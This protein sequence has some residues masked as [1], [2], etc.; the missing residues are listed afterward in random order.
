VDTN[1]GTDPGL[2]E[3]KKRRT[4]QALTEAAL[5]LFAERGFDATTVADIA[6]AA[7]V[8]PRT[9]FSYF[10][11]KEDAVLGDSAEEFELAQQQLTA[12]PP[13]EP[14][15]HAMRRLT[16]AVVDRMRQQWDQ[17]LVRTQVITNTPAILARIRERWDAWEAILAAELA[18]ELG[19]EP[20]DVEPYVAAAAVIGAFRA[21]VQVSI[22]TQMRLDLPAV[23]NRA[24]D[25]LETELATYGA[26]PPAPASP[27]AARP[28]PASTGA[29]AAP[30]KR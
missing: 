2:R 1:T 18:A 17:E 9:F 24:F 10:A 29:P 15:L 28:Q 20:G 26:H 16:L 3:R 27:Q 22:L 25:L 7:D 12:R 14:V 13:G 30:R 8:A 19:A 11:T 4:R 21:V 6:A 5:R 23:V